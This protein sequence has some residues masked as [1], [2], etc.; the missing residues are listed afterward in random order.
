MEGEAAVAAASPA[1]SAAV[2]GLIFYGRR[3]YS[4][5][6]ATRR[7]RMKLY[8]ETAGASPAAAS[9]NER[10]PPPKNGGSLITSGTCRH[11]IVLS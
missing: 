8:R 10:R 2:Y 1:A 4:Q 9:L 3:H 7:P 6:G 5:I 11:M